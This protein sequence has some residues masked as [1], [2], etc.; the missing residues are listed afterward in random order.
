MSD[1]DWFFANVLYALIT[2]NSMN[3]SNNPAYKMAVFISASLYVY[4]G[5][6]GVDGIKI[7]ISTF[8]IL[9]SA[10]ICNKLNS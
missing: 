7:Y 6:V 4:R 9:V 5:Y 1:Q 8:L 2:L 3:K 10:L